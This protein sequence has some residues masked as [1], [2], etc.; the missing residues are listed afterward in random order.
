MAQPTVRSHGPRVERRPAERRGHRQPS[1][2]VAAGGGREPPVLQPG[3][4]QRG[5]VGAGRDRRHDP[6]RGG[7]LVGRIQE[8]D[9]ADLAGLADRAQRGAERA[10]V[11]LR[12]GVAHRR[13]PGPRAE[14]ID[15]GVDDLS[16]HGVGQCGAGVGDARR[17]RQAE[18]HVA[19]GNSQPRC[20]GAELGVAGGDE[21]GRGQP[22]PHDPSRAR[23]AHPARQHRARPRGLAGRHEHEVH[24][25]RARAGDGA[26]DRGAHAQRLVVLVRHQ[27][28]QRRPPAG[29]RRARRL[30][31]RA[32][33]LG[34]RGRR[35][36]RRDR[37][38]GRRRRC[39]PASYG[40]ERRHRRERCAAPASNPS[41]PLRNS[42]IDTHPTPPCMPPDQRNPRAG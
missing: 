36:S 26:P 22:V 1:D 23:R 41:G 40:D 19:G 34:R 12:V 13:V 17:A 3:V 8:R 15:R 20:G 25:R 31:R 35:D 5:P 10:V 4:A 29:G 30:G 16:C 28:H 32:R 24:A 33:R 14:A 38:R 9:R 18:V 37:G 39:D 6:P 21:L 11:G 42:S 2:A 7:E 27:V